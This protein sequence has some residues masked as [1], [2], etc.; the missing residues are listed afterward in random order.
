VRAN[1]EGNLGF[2]TDYRRLN[3][4]ITRARRKLVIIGHEHTLVKDAMYRELLAGID[5][6]INW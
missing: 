5:Q 2:L 6:K 4:S 1:Q 3:V